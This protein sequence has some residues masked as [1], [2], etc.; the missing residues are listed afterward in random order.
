MLA[1]ISEELWQCIVVWHK[2]LGKGAKEIAE[3]T[4]CSKRSVYNILNIYQEFGQVN[5][6][7]LRLLGCPRNL[8]IGSRRMQ[9]SLRY[10][11]Q[12]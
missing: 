2:E 5:D 4:G 9:E 12:G 8:D 6:P 11:W 1:P 10:H 3:L 7:N